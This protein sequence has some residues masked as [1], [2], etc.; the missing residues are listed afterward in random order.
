MSKAKAVQETTNAESLRSFLLDNGFR[1]LTD[2]QDGG[3]TF[4]LWTTG[5]RNLI[6]QQYPGDHGYEVWRP[7]T[8][9][10]RIDVTFDAI[11]R[12]AKEER[13]A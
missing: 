8:L 4:T 9:S 10:S 12:Y 7:V 5:I 2:W 3:H 13:D 1:Q 6:V 11:K